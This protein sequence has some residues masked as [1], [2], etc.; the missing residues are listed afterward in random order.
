MGRWREGARRSSPAFQQ[1][2]RTGPI[3]HLNNGLPQREP[4]VAPLEEQALA[5]RWVSP[6]SP[7]HRLHPGAMVPSPE[8]APPECSPNAVDPD[9]VNPAYSD[10]REARTGQEPPSAPPEAYYRS[11]TVMSGFTGLQVVGTS[12]N[13]TAVAY[14]FPPPETAPPELPPMDLDMSVVQ[15][16]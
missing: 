3:Q 10:L 12:W 16:W 15:D 9:S 6:V 2:V 8:T 1:S 7:L 14:G 4:N 11:Q 13:Q 5:D